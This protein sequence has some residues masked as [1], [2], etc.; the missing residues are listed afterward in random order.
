M[1]PHTVTIYNKYMAGQEE[2]WQRTVL[3]GV[4]WD[5]SK[6]AQLRKAVVAS[7]DG[8]TLI[9][10]QSVLSGYAKP[11]AWAAL[12]DKAGRWTMQSGDIVIKGDV[13]H[14]VVRLTKELLG[15]DDLLTITAVDS[16]EYGGGMA[17]WEVTGR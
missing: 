3:R 13:A 9:I 5:S 17:H 2:R 6:G 4:F 11:K 10:P 14:E 7:A 1:F 16:R 8:L 15:Y 12:T